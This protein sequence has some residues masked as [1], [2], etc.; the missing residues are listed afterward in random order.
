VRKARLL[1]L[2]ATDGCCGWKN[3]P[4]FFTVTTVEQFES[5]IRQLS[6]QEMRRVRDFL[7]DLVEDEL[8]FTNQFEAQIRES[9]AGINQDGKP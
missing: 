5:A 8:Q 6:P 3:F 4:Y 2:S 9:E 1:R 7:D